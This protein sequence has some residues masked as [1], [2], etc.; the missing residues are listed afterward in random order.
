MGRR[1]MSTLKATSDRK[2]R[3]RT[4][5]KNALGL[6]PGNGEKGTCP[7]MTVGEGGCG[8]CENGRKLATCYVFGLIAA[9]KGVGPVLEHNTELL[10]NSDYGGKLA[11]L[12]AEFK[13]FHEAEQRAKKPGDYYRIHW[14]G[15]VY[16][17]E[18]ARALNAAVRANGN[19]KFWSYTR[20]FQFAETFAKDAGN[21]TLYLSLDPVNIEE[22]LETYFNYIQNSKIDNI[23]I[24]YLSKENNFKE[25]Y[26]KL[27]EERDKDNKLPKWP[28]TPPI[29]TAC[30]QDTGKLELEGACYKC[31]KCLTGASN[32]WFKTK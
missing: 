25:T 14:S 27:K 20:S 16:D 9:F 8:E 6:Y 23:R 11:L 7:R 31:R 28:L 13:R 2:T 3:V 22:G 5:Q 10:K 29:L 4:T 26:K 1:L 15:D 32:I 30:P 18:Y 17:E 21:L 19:I 24:C 12:N